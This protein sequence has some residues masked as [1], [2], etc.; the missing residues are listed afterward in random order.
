MHRPA[1]MPLTNIER[2]PIE[3]EILAKINKPK[4]MP[5]KGADIVKLAANKLT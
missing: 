3:S 4:P 2:L 5:N 1:I